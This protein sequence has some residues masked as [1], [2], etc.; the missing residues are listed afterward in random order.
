MDMSPACTAPRQPP[1]SEKDREH[2]LFAL[3]SQHRSACNRLLVEASAFRDWLF[4]YER[5]LVNSKA[6]S[7]PRYPAFLDWMQGSQAGARKCPAGVFP[8]NFYFWIE[9]GRW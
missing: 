5:D 1:I 4:Q 8:H 7:D 6:A 3:Y 9:G 2:P